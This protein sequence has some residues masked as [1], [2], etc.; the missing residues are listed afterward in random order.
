VGDLHLGG[1]ADRRLEVRL[2][3]LGE[4][5]QR[6]QVERAGVQAAVHEGDVG[7]ENGPDGLL[8]RVRDR[9]VVG[10]LEDLELLEPVGLH[11]GSPGTGL[12][13]A[14]KG[15]HQLVHGH[16]A[17]PDSLDHLVTDR[18]G[19]RFQRLLIRPVQG[20]LAAFAGEEPENH[21]AIG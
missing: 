12:R 5:F 17:V 15:C 4:A 19:R 9:Q 14:E 8:C 2:E 7:R 11:G 16:G 6:L 18:R 20:E 13:V 1:V 21:G 10:A 3:R